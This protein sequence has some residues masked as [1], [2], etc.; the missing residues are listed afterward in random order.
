MKNIIQ[1]LGEDLNREGLQASPERFAKMC[2]EI[3]AG[4]FEEPPKLSIFSSPSEDS[5]IVVKNIPFHSMCEHH[6]LPFFGEMEIVYIPQNEKI[7]GFSEVVQVV[8]YFSHRLQIQERLT[9]QIADY[10]NQQL[11]PQGVLVISRATQLCMSMRGV[12]SFTTRTEVIKTSGAFKTK[13]HLLQEA[14]SLLADR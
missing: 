11:S 3:F 5:M 12:K 7:T 14:F 8:R 1:G 2:E 4:Y 13:D 10:L 9:A 6:F